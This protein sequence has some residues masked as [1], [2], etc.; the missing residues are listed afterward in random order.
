MATCRKYLG[1]DATKR[2]DYI[3]DVRTS[4]FP[5]KI[6]PNKCEKEHQQFGTNQSERGSLM[7]N[8]KQNE[9]TTLKHELLLKT[10]WLERGRGGR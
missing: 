8:I 9:I 10:K 2:S 4:L 3:M 6:Q 7:T 1:D 5:S